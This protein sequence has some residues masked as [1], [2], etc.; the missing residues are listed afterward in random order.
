[1]L[2]TKE[3]NITCRNHKKYYIEKGYDWVYQK[4]IIVKIED[5]SSGSHETVDVLCDY[6]NKNIIKKSYYTYNLQNKNSTIKKDCCS[7]CWHL[8]LEDS[9]L[10]K[11]G[12]NNVSNIKEFQDKKIKT[13]ISNFGTDNPM[14]NAKI[15]LKGK[16]TNLDKYGVDHIMKLDGEYDK[17]IE[18]MRQTM[19]SNGNGIK[20]TQQ[21]YLQR[22]IGGEI[23][24]PVGKYLLDIAFVEDLIY[25][26]F[27][28]SGHNLDVQLNYMTEEEKQ[29]K[30]MKR[31]YF[32]KNR[33]WKFIRFIS[34]KDKFPSKNILKYLIDLAFYHLK[35]AR[36]YFEINIDKGLIKYN[37]NEIKID[38][39]RLKRISKKDL[40]EVI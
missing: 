24:Y 15:V 11:Y 17:R 28:G 13:F 23:N 20:S 1:M 4:E 37:N 22:A 27:D 36:S 19:F 39:G 31:F 33:G 25:C 14:K 32:M 18:K 35:N 2:L 29:I 40:K 26:E 34:T 38:F 6:C 30:E 7:D 12:K 10:K 5:L 9:M 21:I 3:I 16:Q 8:K